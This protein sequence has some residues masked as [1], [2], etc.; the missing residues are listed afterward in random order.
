VKPTCHIYQTNSNRNEQN[1]APSLGSPQKEY[2]VC[3]IAPASANRL[4]STYVCTATDSS[5]GQ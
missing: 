2:Q 4:S 1:G 5:S 3:K